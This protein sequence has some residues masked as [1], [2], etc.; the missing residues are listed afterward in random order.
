MHNLKSEIGLFKIYGGLI[1]LVCFGLLSHL[2]E[3]WAYVCV[4]SNIYVILFWSIFVVETIF[5]FEVVS[6]QNV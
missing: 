3:I 1:K 5:S 2:M 6:M 4:C